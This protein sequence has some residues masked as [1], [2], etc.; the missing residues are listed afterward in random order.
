M[1]EAVRQLVRLRADNR[2]EYCHLPQDALP[3]ARF[4]IEHIRA[5]QHRGNDEPENLAV[6]C[7]KCNLHKGPN[8]SSIDPETDELVPL[9]NPRLDSWS[10]H[11]RLVENQIVGLTAI[12]RATSVLLEMNDQDRIQ[13]RAELTSQGMDLS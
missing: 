2:C 8:L 5:K 1:E 4:Q 13:L 10:E 12:G 9:F 11:F 3:W 7:R 6:A